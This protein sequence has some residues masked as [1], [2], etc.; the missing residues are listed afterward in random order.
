MPPMLKRLITVSV[1]AAAC[2]LGAPREAAAF[3]GFY[4]S[5][6]DAKLYNNATLV[7]LMRD[8]TRTVLSMQNN[9]QGPPANFAMVVPV[10]VVLQKDDVKTLPREIF[11]R[12]DQLAAPRLVEYWEM[13]PC[14]REPKRD[15]SGVKME[16]QRGEAA[17]RKRLLRLVERG[18]GEAKGACGMCDGSPVGLHTPDH[19][20]LHLEQVSG[21]EELRLAE[22]VVGDALGP[23]VERSALAEGFAF[24][25]RRLPVGHGISVV[26]QCRYIMP[27]SICGQAW[28]R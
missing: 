18:P 5:G 17:T 15:Y 8:G 12:V 4:V 25:V 2:A 20:V 24:G 14:Y 27:H 11:D 10:P 22:Q 26:G 1:L 16:E 9:Y 6:G 13:D 23:G 21:I 19:L 3:C 28:I 7:V